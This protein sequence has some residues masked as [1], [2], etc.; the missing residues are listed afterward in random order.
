M[1]KYY[2]L[3]PIFVVSWRGRHTM[4]I[5]GLICITAHA[6]L[7]IK[8]QDDVRLVLCNM[9]IKKIGQKV[10]FKDSSFLLFVFSMKN[11]SV[12]AN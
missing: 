8:H 6:E 12:Y 10:T 7:F 5:S 9:R 4:Y 1:I 11:V 3:T 2:A